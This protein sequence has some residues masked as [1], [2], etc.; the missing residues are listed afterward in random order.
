MNATTLD[1]AVLTLVAANAFA[2]ERYLDRTIPARTRLAEARDEL[3]KELREPTKPHHGGGGGMITHEYRLAQFVRQFHRIVNYHDE[4]EKRWR[5]DEQAFVELSD[6]MRNEE[7]PRAKEAMMIAL[8]CCGDRTHETEL[9]EIVQRKDDPTPRGFT[10]EA[11]GNNGCRAAIPVLLKQLE[12]PYEVPAGCLRIH[13]EETEFPV[14]DYSARALR[15]LGVT[16]EYVKRG[17]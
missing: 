9:I 14:R 3:Y 7:N 17:P 4:T 2:G 6:M 16:V 10:I 11:L 15:R 5:N 13:G 8:A 1:L 12:D